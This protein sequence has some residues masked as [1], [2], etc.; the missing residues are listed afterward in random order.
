MNFHS[1]KIGT[2][3]IRT[4]KDDEKLER[5][6]NEIDKADLAICGLQ[7]VRRLNKGSALV[8]SNS[9]KK[10][11][12]HWS[13]HNNKR[14]HGVGIVIKVDTSIEIVEIIPVDARII[15]ADAIVR[16]CSLK[17]INCYAPTEE[18]TESSKNLF[19]RTLN[20]QVKSVKKNQK[21]I[22]IGDFN[23][24]TSAVW[25]NTSLREGSIIND[26]IVNNNGERFHEFFE[27]NKLSV[28][29]TW[30]THK[31]C[32]RITWHSSDGK[33]K[34]VYD[35]ILC[36][37]WLRRYVT[38]CRVFNSFD[39]DSDHRLVVANLTTPTTKKARF[40]NR[41]K[42][43]RQ[44]RIN[45]EAIT[46]AM[47]ELF[48]DE[49][50][51][52]L[53]SNE[54]LNSESNDFLNEKLVNTIKETATTCF[55][56]VTPESQSTPWKT[57]A[58]LQELFQTKSE[59]SAK[60]ANPEDI[61]RIRKKIRLRARYL[62]NE[63][64]RHEAEKLNTYATNKQI[65]KLFHRAKRQ[66]T[67]LKP[68]NNACPTDKLL[69]HFKK[70]FNPTDP[71]IHSS[72]EEISQKIPIF[73]KELQKI[74]D[75]A[76]INDLPP[77]DDEIEKHIR[78]L[79]NSKASNDVEAELLKKC[80]HPIM[81]QVIQRITNNLWENLDLPNAWGNSHLRTLWKGKGSKK[82]ASKYRGLSIGSTICKL[83]VNII[84]FR[85]RDWYECQLT[86]EQNG[87]RPN[88]GTT[89]GI[90][91]VKRIHQI[92]HRKEQP[93]YLLFVDLSAAFDHIPRKWLFDTI[94]LRFTDKK[95]PIMINMLEKLY[96]HTSLTYEGESFQTSAGVRQGG[97]ESPFLFNLYLDF[98][99]RLILE[100]A[101]MND[102]IKFF[103]HK[104]H[105]STSSLSRAERLSI[106]EK[107]INLSSSS[108][109]PWCGYADDLVLFL[110]DQQS[111]QVATIVLDNVFVSFGLS[112]NVQKTETMILN[113]PVISPYPK[114]IV[115]LNEC[116]LSNVSEFKYLGAY[117]DCNQPNTGE[118]EINH[119]IQL[120]NAK[121]QQL[122]NLIQNF[123]INLKTR[124]LFLNSFV[125]SRLVY[126]CQNWNLTQQQLDRVNAVYR[127]LLRRMIR[128][129]FKFV[130]PDAN[131]YRYAISNAQLH[132]ICGTSDVSFFI[133]SQQHHYVSHIIRMPVTRTVKL[134]TFNEDHYTKRGR[135]TKSLLD[136]VIEFKNVTL[137]Q[138]FTL[139]LS[140]KT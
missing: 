116:Q 11:E 127:K 33:T 104:Y 64:F 86:D 3:N 130:N 114:S 92:S 125:R 129:G 59:L 57:D 83:V 27:L 58:K 36:T 94:R 110:K 24:S 87:F 29:N 20:K 105:I 45:F 73:V 122:S 79:K 93:L 61:K 68:T 66:E 35:F 44:K 49:V 90:Y 71:S 96:Q 80:S 25:S 55:P 120:A 117:L 106:R 121:F 19:Y 126:A 43:K 81:M 48:K 113:H 42:T 47:S 137:N 138:Y 89:D 84:L 65:E 108:I 78:L 63:H 112:V 128:G 4:G 131:D 37:S 23:A 95:L 85:L 100:K 133:R 18:S 14:T 41:T 21:L 132:G 136:Q 16:G 111:L 51:R 98:V 123:R 13:G 72:P 6:V 140:K 26:L 134:L 54:I 77:T 82:D 67:T 31:R 22:C 109:L 101:H 119:R 135:P 97:P 107:N 1:W 99:M 75:S 102:D 40:I 38:N 28:L 17:I 30:F 91:T 46:P 15:V 115:E 34:K 53:N 88:R 60:N 10:Y 69:A 2:I 56:T 76:F 74:S 118:K 39:F 139:A 9:G 32:R 5:V 124:I 52:K 70:H 50:S 103:D 7:E 8:K 12:V 62:K